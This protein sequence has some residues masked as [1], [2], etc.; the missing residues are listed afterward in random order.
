MRL[1]RDWLLRLLLLVVS[2]TFV[3]GVGELAVRTVEGR[4]ERVARPPRVKPGPNLPRLK[5]VRDLQ[6]P[7]QRGVH[8][9]VLYETNSRGLRA[10]ELEPCA[11]EGVFRIAIGGDSVTVGWGVAAEHTY[12]HQLQLLLDADP[13]SPGQRHEVI[14][15]GL[16]AMNARYAISRLG[17]QARFYNADLVVYG[18]T[19]ND[20][21]GPDYV[22]SQPDEDRP[23]ALPGPSRYSSSPSHL[24]RW[25]WP[26]WVSLR[27]LLIQP[28]RSPWAE[29]LYNYNENPAAFA[30]VERALGSF[31]RFQKA[32]GVCAHV[33]VHTQFDPLGWL[34]PWRR[35]YDQV[36]EA[37][38]RA[39]LTASQA[40][41][42]FRGKSGET[43]WLDRYDSHPNVQGHALFARALYEDLR[44][45]PA[46]CWK[47]RPRADRCQ[48]SR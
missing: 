12:S 33:F 1:L 44:A 48:G 6:Q 37:S 45:L 10:P 39:G 4:R 43:F 21:E 24:V 27:D 3:F 14:N 5:S 46:A 38:E 8:R 9:H 41:R 22:R 16:A 11:E 28:D 35:V 23:H 42:V 34:H 40:F 30:Q 7:N 19:V 29:L 25:A 2:C 17:N 32:Q 47:P 26:R 20:I 15:T 18:Y 13:L 31:A 36:A